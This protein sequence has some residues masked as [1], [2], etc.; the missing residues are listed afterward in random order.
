MK[1]SI[2]CLEKKKRIKHTCKAQ[3]A[4]PT[5]GIR[6]CR[7]YALHM[8]LQLGIVNII[9]WT[10]VTLK[11]TFAV[12]LPMHIQVD[13]IIKGLLA[14]FTLVYGLDCMLDT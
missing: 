13:S 5:N 9:A 7:M 14:Y 4:Y 3:L 1:P 12:P 6:R 2:Y 8:R 10:E 11:V